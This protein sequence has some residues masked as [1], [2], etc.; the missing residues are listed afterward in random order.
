MAGPAQHPTSQA[1]SASGGR[2]AFQPVQHRRHTSG[3]PSFLSVQHA[4]SLLAVSLFTLLTTH[5]HAQ[6]TLTTHPSQ[7]TPNPS[8]SITRPAAPL[9]QATPDDGDPRRISEILIAY[10]RPNPAHPTSDQVLEATLD[11]TF[12][13]TGFVAPRAAGP[14][15]RLRLA[16]L[17][18]LEAIG[19]PI[20]IHDSALA[21][22]APAIVQRLQSLGLV[23]VYAEPDSTQLRV[24]DG[25][26]IDSRPT[27]STSITYILT[28]GIVTQFRTVGLG[29][30]LPEDQTVNNPVH[31]RIL[32]QSPVA[33]ADSSPHPDHAEG[34]EAPPQRDLLRA[35]LIDRYVMRL[36]RHPGRRVD[37][38]V[39]AG[40]DDFGGV[41]LD[42]LVTENRP[43]LLFAQLA[44]NGTGSTNEW[45][46]RF[47]FIHNQLSNHDDIFSVEYLTANFEDVNSLVASYERPIFDPR[48]RARAFASWYEYTA[49]EV[50]QPDADF[51]G[52]GWS[53]G[54]ELIWNFFQHRETFLDLAAGARFEGLRVDNELADLSGQE[55][56][57]LAY[58][59]LRLERVRAS[60]ATFAS[61]TLEGSLNGVDGNETN[62]L[63]RTDADDDWTTLSGSVNHS[64][65]LEPLFD[66]N[67]DE[68]VS[69]AHE[70]ALAARFQSS[71]GNRLIPNYQ[72]VLGGLYTV[73]GY[74][75]SI[76][77]GDSI[78]LATAE[79][80]FHLPHALTPN[81]V[82]G[83]FASQPFR[84]RPQYAY[85]PTDWDLILKAFIDIG[86][87]DTSDALAFEDDYTL[88]GAGIGAELA[89]TRRFNVRLD[90][91]WALEEIDS[92]TGGPTV[93]SGDFEA[94]FV[95]TIVF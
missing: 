4:R 43:W 94:H 89:L 66:P 49:S 68:A 60:S 36:N 40:G 3:V 20:H 32:A 83:E 41:T 24:E 21:L 50:G 38:A 65:Y 87:T 86:T 19:G 82:P 52:D 22:I 95:L 33:P 7:P 91:G 61:L 25:F 72:Q 90:L 28:T 15:T 70:I 57:T 88:I 37:V 16:D 80:R 30:R 6:T 31:A 93:D 53:A 63:G 76:V 18:A 55:A 27:G 85:G 44:N 69:L 79:Y 34:A 78:A 1:Q 51:D 9:P 5:T 39:S 2:R 10:A 14:I 29:E 47:G 26:V 46:E 45:R 71:L 54:A 48:L 74:P 64:F 12:T 77:A 73:R 35:D 42:Y 59:S 11:L 62:T 13:P 81:P 92:D 58:A 67:A 17:P 56:L 75:E 8:T 23:G 84:W